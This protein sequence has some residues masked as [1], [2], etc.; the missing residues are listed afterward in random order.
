MVST[1]GRQGLR[2]GGLIDELQGD[3]D[4]FYIVGGGGG[5]QLKRSG[6]WHPP[7]R[8]LSEQNVNYFQG[9][10]LYPNSGKKIHSL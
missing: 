2:R 7:S 3:G 10:S 1:V 9:V 8:T 5:G 6:H 4:R